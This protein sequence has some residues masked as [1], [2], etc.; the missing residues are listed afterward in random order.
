[1]ARVLLETMFH[2]DITEA[3]RDTVSDLIENKNIGGKMAASVDEQIHQGRPPISTIVTGDMFFVCCNRERAKS[4]G[5][6][7]KADY[8]LMAAPLYSGFA[9]QQVK[10]L[11]QDPAML[12][13]DLDEHL[14]V[15]A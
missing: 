1:M 6:D 10:K 7:S 15:A 11:E 13:I 3:Q 9:Q 2:N 8:L 5:H 14:E 4:E 12:R